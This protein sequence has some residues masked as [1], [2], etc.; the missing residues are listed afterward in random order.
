MSITNP[1]RLCASFSLPHI[2][3]E[4]LGTLYF[5]AVYD[6]CFFYETKSCKGDPYSTDLLKSSENESMIFVSL[7]CGLERFELIFF[8]ICFNGKP[9]GK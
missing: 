7:L 5:T 4:F 8:L 6:I 9:A 2:V 1:I 3:L